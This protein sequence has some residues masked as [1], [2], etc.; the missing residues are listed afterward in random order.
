MVN[1]TAVA[2]IRGR[3]L[4]FCARAMCGYYS[5][6]ATIRCGATIRVNTVLRESEGEGAWREAGERERGYNRVQ[7]GRVCVYVCV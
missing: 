6:A 7:G 4:F 1:S 2:T 3:L 5:K